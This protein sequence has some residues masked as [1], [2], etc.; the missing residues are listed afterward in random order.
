[1]PL[2]SIAQDKLI[3]WINS[4]KADTNEEK[5]DRFTL[6]GRDIMAM[7]EIF[8]E[9]SE[10]SEELVS[11]GLLLSFVGGTLNRDFNDKKDDEKEKIQTSLVKNLDDAIEATK[12]NNW[13]DFHKSIR[14]IV[15]VIYRRV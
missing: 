11:S 3:S 13:L 8:T 1:M 14:T 5:F 15:Y 9:D 4:L 6:R 2:N 10:W 12:K 7:G